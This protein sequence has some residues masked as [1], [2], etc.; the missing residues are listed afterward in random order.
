LNIVCYQAKYK[1]RYED[2]IV[3][4][5]EISPESVPGKTI[6]PSVI[7]ANNMIWNVPHAFYNMP[8]VQDLMERMRRDLSVFLLPYMQDFLRR[9]GLPSDKY[10]SI[11]LV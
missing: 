3:I 8:E 1:E 6:T 10:V 4:V 7:R 2:S 11:R 5:L 9:A